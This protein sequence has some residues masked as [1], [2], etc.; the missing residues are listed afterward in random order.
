MY[1]QVSLD[2]FFVADGGQERGGVIVKGEIVIKVEY[3]DRE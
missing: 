1:C 3:D 2:Y